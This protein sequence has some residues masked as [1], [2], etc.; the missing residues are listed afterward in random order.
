MKTPRK[1]PLE[2]EIQ[3]AILQHWRL[4]GVPGSLV[5]AIPNANCHGQPGVTPGL[6]DLLVMSPQLGGL[7]AYIEVKAEGGRPSKAQLAMR[8]FM[9]KR[10]TPYRLTYGRDEPIAQLEAWGAIRPQVRAAA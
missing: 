6:P 2:K 4:L 8:D 5:A 7:T 9:R 3:A 10:G 1:G